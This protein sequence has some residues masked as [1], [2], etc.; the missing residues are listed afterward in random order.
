MM[1]IHQVLKDTAVE[2]AAVSDSPELDAEILLS[3]VLNRQR[4][5]LR[6]HAADSLTETD[7]QALK[8]LVARRLKREPVAYLVGHKE[9]WSLDLDVNQHTLVPRP[10]TE[11]IVEAALALFPDTNQILRVVDL[12]TGSGAIALALQSERLRWAI[13]AV[14]ISESALTVAR[15]NA[16]RLGLGRI[17]F[18][19]GNWFTA[20]PAGT[21]DLVVT[22]PPYLSEVEWP[23]YADGLAAEPRSALVSGLDGLDAI[24]DIL[25][26]APRMIR[27]GGYILIEHGLAQGPAVCALLKL[28]GCVAVRTLLDLAGRERVSVGQY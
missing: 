25:R 28:S 26:E 24:R 13:S 22:N 21:F 17:S 3:H 2:L 7:L 16:Q 10:E 15:N 9:F 5:Y 14:D 1:S 8:T 11:L 20:L 19:L 27:P 6:S 18:Y 23:V 12:G 4:S